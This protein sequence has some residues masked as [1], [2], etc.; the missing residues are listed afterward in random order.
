MSSEL[1]LCALFIKL[2]GALV[3]YH[4][5]ETLTRTVLENEYTHIYKCPPVVTWDFFVH[6]H[7]PKLHCQRFS[8]VED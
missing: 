5:L 6:L 8:K 1:F 7:L 4:G 3:Y 2:A